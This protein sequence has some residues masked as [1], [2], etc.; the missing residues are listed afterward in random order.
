MFKTYSV[1]NKE[2]YIHEDGRIMIRSLKQIVGDIL[3]RR[4][5]W[6]QTLTYNY[7]SGEAIQTK[8]FDALLYVALNMN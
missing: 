2:W 3:T 7:N 5:T 4:V 6:G 8:R 1:S